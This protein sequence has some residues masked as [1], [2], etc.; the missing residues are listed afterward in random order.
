M[1]DIVILVSGI[2]GA[3]TIIIF[4]IFSFIIGVRNLYHLIFKPKEYIENNHGNI[5]DEIIAKQFG[6]KVRK[7]IDD[8]I[9]ET[10]RDTG[11]YR[12]LDK[13]KSVLFVLTKQ[14]I[15]HEIKK[16]F[17]NYRFRLLEVIKKNSLKVDSKVGKNTISSYSHYVNLRSILPNS[18]DATL[19]SYIL[20]GFIYENNEK[21][22]DFIAVNRNSNAIL[23]YLI[24]NFLDLPLL[25]VNY[26]T[27][28]EIDGKK[29]N[30]DGL[31]SLRRHEGKKGFLV[32]DAVSGGS[33]LKESC[34]ILKNNGLVVEDVFVLFTRKEDD[35]KSDFSE[36]D[37]T[38]HSIFDLDDKLIEKIIFTPDKELNKLLN[39]I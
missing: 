19:I 1:N 10:M 21:G 18:E 33:I 36:V 4:L 17:Q 20:A 22:Y 26:D 23:G 11:V 25:I 38:L 27:R 31:S 5:L 28:W 13:Q 2:T 15:E 32:D 24:S 30:I 16:N 6:D 14:F 35:A 34:F 9:I 7:I 8:S 12:N 29:L 37:I 39:E 3:L